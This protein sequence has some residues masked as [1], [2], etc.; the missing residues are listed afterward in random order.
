MVRIV[1]CLRRRPGLTYDEFSQ[2]WWDHHAPLVRACSSV[3]RIRRYEQSRPI[4]GPVATALRASREAPPAYYGIATIWFDHEDDIAAGV[5]TPDGRRAART[6]LE[7]E[8]RFIDLA[9]SPITLVN[10]R[11]VPLT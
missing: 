5:A 4:S 2:Y 10:D 8:R 7:D 6:L 3:L 11:D 1:F 9:N